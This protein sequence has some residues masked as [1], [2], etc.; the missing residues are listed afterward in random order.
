M[1]FLGV[2][3]FY[4]TRAPYYS[5]EITFGEKISLLGGNVFLLSKNGSP[6]S[7]VK[8][9]GL[10]SGTFLR[11]SLSLILVRKNFNYFN[12]YSID[13]SQIFTFIRNNLN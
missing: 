10:T 6:P 7:L 3:Q 13:I 4:S 5:S 1:A 11:G 12:F 8:P 2:A 9:F